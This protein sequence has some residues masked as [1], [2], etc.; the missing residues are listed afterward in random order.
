MIGNSA[1]LHQGDETPSAAIYSHF[2]GLIVTGRLAVGERLP[3]VRQTAHDLGV[4]SG[5]A[6]RAY[7][8]L[9]RDGYVTSR[10]GAGTRVAETTTGL[11]RSVVDAIRALTTA[12][13]AHSVS[14]HD[15]ISALRAEWT[16]GRALSF[17]PRPT[18]HQ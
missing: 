14:E 5:T 7:K 13:A 16:E 15:V 11:P 3:T 6:A 8:Q 9:E 1:G 4:A 18:E 2:R 10:T 17:R 12:A